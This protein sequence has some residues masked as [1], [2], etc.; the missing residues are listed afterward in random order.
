MKN[1]FKA[2]CGTFFL[3]ASILL[4]LPLMSQENQT[5]LGVKVNITSAVDQGGGNYLV[6]AQ[7]QDETNVYDGTDITTGQNFWTKSLTLG[8]DCNKYQ[9][10]D[11]SCGGCSILVGQVTVLVNDTDSQGSPTIG[12]GAVA[13]TTFVGWVSGIGND[14]N[15]CLQSF[16][17]TQIQTQIQAGGGSGEANTAS[18]LGGDEGLFT[19]KSGVDLPFKGLTAGSGISLSSDANAVTIT[20]TVIPGAS[21][22]LELT[23]SPSSYSGQGLQGVRVNA[24]ETALEFF[25]VPAGGEA[26][27]ASNLGAG[28]GLFTTKSGVDLPFKSLV[29]GTGISL[30]SDANTVT[31]A[32][33]DSQIDHDALS[34]FVADEHIA[35]SSVTMTAG[36]GISGGG[37]IA[38]T[39]TFDLDFSELSLVTTFE[40][41]DQVPLWDSGTGAE[42]RITK[43]NFE[44]GLSITEA[45]ISDLSHYTTS[46]FNTDFATKSTTDLGEGTNLY[47]TD[48]RVDDRTAALIQNGTGLSWTYDDGGN[49][50][51]GNV[52]DNTTTQRVQVG[53]AG[54]VI[55]TRQEINFIEGTGMVIGIVDNA[56]QDRVDVTLT[57]TGAGG[58]EAN[59]AS[60]VGAAGV[61]VFKQKTGVD[62][63]FKNINAGSSK[64]TITD[65]TG[66]DEL[67]VDVDQTAIDHDQLL[68][69]VADEHIAHSSVTM[70]AGT[71]ISGGGTIAATRTFD[72]DFSELSLVTTFEVDD[73]VPLWDSGT[74]AEERITKANFEAGLSIAESQ[75]SDLDH[76]AT[77]DFNTDFAT[78]STTDLGEGTNLYFTDERVDDRTA[79]LI[80]NGTGLSWTYDDGGNT[81]T[82]NVQDNTTTQ[83]VQVGEAGTVAGTRQEINFI[84]GTNITLTVADNAGQDRVDVTINSAAGSGE[85]NTASNLGA[86]EGLFTT[87]SGV[88]LP[89]KSL[90][91][92]TGISLSSDA[93]TVT[94][95]TNDSQIDH[96]ALSNFV[97]DEHIAH[98]SVTMTAGV[99]LSGGGT[100]AATRTFDLDFSELSLVTTFEAD[101]QVP[102]W[103]SGTGAEERITKANFEA[104][105]SIVESQISDLDH[106]ATSDF[107]TD[108]ATKSTTDLGE[109]TNLYFTDERVD[110]RTAALIQNGTG[111]SWTYD[112]GG[113]TLT[114]NV[115]NNTTTQRVQVGEAGTVAGTRQEINFIE[116]TNI[117]LT[118]ADN[119]GQDRVDVTISGPAGAGEANTA[120]NLGGDEGLFTTKSGVDLPF[121]G[122]TA[123]SGISLSSD[124]NAVTITLGTHAGNHIL[125]GSDVIDGDHLDIT[126]T[127]SVYTPTTTPPEASNLDH[128]T[129]HLGGIDDALDP[130]TNANVG[131]QTSGTVDL[132]SKQMYAVKIDM[133]GLSSITMTLNNPINAGVYVFIFTNADDGD[134]VTWTNV[135]YEDGSTVGNDILSGGRRMITMIYDGTNYFTY[136]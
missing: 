60:N 104:G 17:M 103:D 73:Q 91:G 64:I 53:E 117:T 72:L 6:T 77:S 27:T 89:F 70:T 94:I 29:G 112:D 35:H 10:T 3:L 40:A 66:N 108:F 11:V 81:L 50:L 75:I 49:T 132:L 32:T 55:G 92:G 25:T 120:S 12:L 71:G 100:I 4:S 1:R 2:T 82:G 15:Q 102:L 95:A 79:A 48:E 26:N 51:T 41:D 36:T 39:R 129:A 33:N 83:R 19:T 31:I 121:K 110:D 23:D 59:T 101:D 86:G 80:Q 122:L 115:Q 116:G 58:G 18:N 128:L 65:D 118:V 28:E 9:I 131:N 5:Q 68:N 46:D 76:Y 63:E 56:G 88:D 125:G 38:A 14:L 119:A 127:P 21:T 47:F 8:D 123:G 45:Q 97:A 134:T 22:F 30:S 126:F 124:A 109:G 74:G 93:N 16:T 37:T 43:A 67:D 57:A 98:S 133:T 99:G 105:L 61:G 85:A 24:G 96:D 113:N 107:N 130:L 136:L 69:F 87:K 135:L 42:E 90:V 84:E 114:G 106:Y 111:L 34:N 7:I 13:D 78:K 52:Q 62:L 20:S 44:A 54:T